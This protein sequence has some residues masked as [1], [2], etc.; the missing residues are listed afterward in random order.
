MNNALYA[1]QA[2]T[3]GIKYVKKTDSVTPCAFNGW[4]TLRMRQ[5]GYRASI[6]EYSQSG[7]GFKIEFNNGDV[8]VGMD[9]AVIRINGEWKIDFVIP[10]MQVLLDM[11]QGFT[12]GLDI[13]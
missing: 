4:I 12:Y 5:S 9:I 10:M 6:G 13:N 2:L 11:M 8:S 3:K 7:D 1:I